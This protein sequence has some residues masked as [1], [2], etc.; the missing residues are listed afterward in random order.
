M[1]QRYCLMNFGS[2]QIGLFFFLSLC[3]VSASLKAQ[4]HDEERYSFE[5]RGET[6]TDVLEEVA[7]KTGVDMVYDPKIVRGINIYSRVHN[8]PVPGLLKGVLE[9]TPLD[10]ITLSSGTIVIVMKVNDDPDYGTFLGKVIDN[11][12]GE[13]LQGATVML[14]EASGGTSTGRSGT[15]SLNR[16]MTGSYK[17]VFS[18]V[19]YEPVYKTIHIEPNQVVREEVALDPKPID[20][21]PII[22]TDHLP[23]LPGSG[24]GEYSIDANSPWETNGKMQDAVRSLSLFSGVQYGLPMTDLHLQ[25][26]QR[27]EHR[28][29]LDG[30]PV[31]NPYSF[32]QMFSAFSPFAISRVELYKA[33]FGVPEGSQIAGLINLNHD[34]NSVAENRAM[35]QGDPLSLNVRGDLHFTGDDDASFKVMAAARSNYWDLYQE[36][37]LD[38]TLREWDDLDPLITDF[39]LDS[40]MD[41][42]LYEP[43]KHNADVRFYDLHLASKYNINAYNSLSSSFYVG[44]NYVSTGLLRQA[45]Q[46]EQLPEYLYARDEYRWNNIMGQLTYHTFVSPRL[47][48]NTRVSFS[49]NRFRHRYLIGTN[50]NPFIPNQNL[51]QLSDASAAY[52]NFKEAEARN[53]VPNQLTANSI[54]HIIVK[55]D[56]TY[57]FTPHFNLEAGVQMDYVESRVDLGDLFYL[58][59]LSDQKSAFFSSYLNGNW[60]I[61]EYW[62]LVLGNRITFVNTSGR[63]YSEPRASIQLDRPDSGIGYWSARL[64]GGLYRQFIN[65]YD[66]T[67]PGPTSLVP[68]FSVWSH[69]GTSEAPKAWH[70]SGSYHLEPAESTTLDLEWFYKWQPTTYTVSYEN[71]LLGNTI[72]RSGFSAFAETTDLKIL[73]AGIRLSQSVVKSKLKLMLGY[74]YSYTRMNLE[75]Q[76]GRALP[77]PW[78]EPHRLQFRTLWHVFADL[79]VV[80][81]WQSVFGRTWGFRRSYY[82]YLFYQGGESV[83]DYSFS[84]PEDDQLSPFHQLDLSFIYKPAFKFA[85]MEV[86]LDLINLL[87]RRNTIDWSLQP[88]RTEEVGTEGQYEKRERTMPGFNPSVSIQVSI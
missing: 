1:D 42:S 66:I 76:F 65:Q 38:R 64:S 35:V 39:L 88:E 34:V 69:A 21:T 52:S 41:P 11:E 54:Q 58:P 63:F 32:G 51:G 24:T 61:G 9:E 77:A 18:Y 57:S 46:N 2:Y 49:S 62:K 30:V 71:L 53:Q 16:L 86:R 82:N 7:R 84:H 83:G 43:R 17:I 48:L 29:M 3:L 20:F 26:G 59:T 23:Q 87:D 75:T 15:F 85:D 28:I 50:Y 19:G 74:D 40:D 44:K 8:Q 55:S 31:Y 56:G 14:A 78:D 47:D 12:T 4:D 68:S 36:P 79:T 13:P 33:G 80:A 22:V 70:L 81:K 27:G 25:G 5:F 10:F 73:G 6:L 60:R 72:N 37:T 45:Q 67:N